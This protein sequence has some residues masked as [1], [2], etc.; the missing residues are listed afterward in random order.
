MTGGIAIV[1]DLRE[2]LARRTNF[3][4]VE[5]MPMTDPECDSYQG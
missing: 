3:E 5:L 1:L 2:T 4:H